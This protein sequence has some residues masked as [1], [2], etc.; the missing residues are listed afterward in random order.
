M[1]TGEEAIIVKLKS[2]LGLAPAGF[3]CQLT[4]RLGGLLIIAAALL[5]VETH[6]PLLA[7]LNSGIGDM[8]GRYHFVGP[9]DTLAIL[10]EEGRLKGFI[11]VFQGEEESDEML[12]YA[13]ELGNR[14][15]EHVEFKTSKIH[16]RYYRFTGVIQRGTGRTGNDTDYMRLVGDLETIIAN[17]VSGKEDHKHLQVVFKLKGKAELEEER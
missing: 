7:Q 13:I 14:Q 9:D 3:R 2:G 17:S 1:L 11:E 6:A 5:L 8:T 4:P 12:S 16:E 10:E 15:G